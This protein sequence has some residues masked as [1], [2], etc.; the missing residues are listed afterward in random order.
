MFIS[1]NFFFYKK[2]YKWPEN[3]CYKNWKDIK[4]HEIPLKHFWTVSCKPKS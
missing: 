4:K 2:R 3:N 1:S